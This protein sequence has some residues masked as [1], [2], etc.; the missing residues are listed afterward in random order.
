M[1]AL[2]VI[3][4]MFVFAAVMLVISQNT[5]TLGYRAPLELDLWLVHLTSP[6]MAMYVFVFLCFILGIIFGALTFYPGNREIRENL[7]LLRNRINLLKEELMTLEQQKKQE[8]KDIQ[9]QAAP[10]EKPIR[11]E[12]V[13]V[14]TSSAWGK[15]AMAGFVITFIL[16]VVFYYYAQT[17]MD[18]LKKRMSESEEKAV[19]LT[20]ATEDSLSSMEETLLSLELKFQDETGKIEERLRDIDEEI[21]ILE[22]QPQK[23]RDYLTL[24]HLQQYMQNLEYLQQGAESEIDREKL[25]QAGEMLQKAIEHYRGK[26]Q[27]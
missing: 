1:N 26:N 18:L 23:T 20:Q 22:R 8:L 16:L 21:Q 6:S 17:E 24:M 11:E 9:E 19:H 2:R 5:A 12:P 3:F 13:L 7:R 15:A 10:E 27:E 4:L 25:D 14:H